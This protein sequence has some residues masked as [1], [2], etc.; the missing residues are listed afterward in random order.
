MEKPKIIPP[1][2]YILYTG[3]TIGM[4]YEKDQGLVPIKGKLNKLIDEMKITRN[5]DITYT[6]DGM[7]PLIDSSNLRTKNWKY[8]LDKLYDNYDKYDSFIVIHGTDTLAYTAS[9]LSFFLKDWNKTVVITGSQIPLFEFR[10]DARQNIV[11]SITVS[12]FKIYEI[13]V[14]FGGKILR[15]NRTTKYSSI[16]FDAYYSP[17]YP[18]IGNIGV[19]INLQEQNLITHMEPA[20]YLEVLPSI[21]TNWDLSKWNYTHIGIHCFT[22]FPEENSF[23]LNALIDLDPAPNVIVLRTYGIGNAPVSDDKFMAS[24]KQAI[25]KNII[26]VNSTQ[27]NRGGVNMT[28]YK[29][30]KELE[31]LGVI[32][33]LDMTLETVYSKLYF[34]LQLFGNDDLDKIKKLFHT[35]IAGELSDN[36]YMVKMTKSVKDYYKGY[37]EM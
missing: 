19:H 26:I 35:N 28:Y 24:I 29:T 32:S 20:D 15:G 3:G 7:D 10:N 6:I 9:A 18:E 5:I 31:K 14:V 17:N 34:L 23:T 36:L 2:I 16:D 11:D 25:E 12:L 1:K 30:G 13:L 8:M 4:T 37:Q 22:L 27:C 21:P 33:S